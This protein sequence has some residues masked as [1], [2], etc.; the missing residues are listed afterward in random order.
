MRGATGITH[1]HAWGPKSKRNLPKTVEGQFTIRLDHDPNMKLQNWTRSLAEVTFSPL[2]N[3]FCIENYRIFAL[4]LAIPNFTKCCASTKKATLQ[5]HEMLRLPRK[6]TLMIDPETSFRVRGATSLPLQLNQ[7]FR[8][9]RK[10]ALQKSKRNLRKTDETSCIMSFTLPWSEHD[11]TMIRP[12]SDHEL[13]LLHR[14]P[15]AEVTCRASGDMFWKLHICPNFTKCCTYHEKSHSNI[16]KCCA[17]HGKWHSNNITNCCAY[18]G[19]RR[20]NSS[21]YCTCHPK[22]LSCLILL[23][24]ETSCT[25][26]GATSLTLQLN[27]IL[28]LPRKIAF[29]NLREICGKTD[30]TSFNVIYIAG[31]I[32]T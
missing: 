11:P 5:D 26:C 30:E 25:M 23:T 20:S 21:K 19:K 18:Y 22:W 16:T 28:R 9:P 2:R 29:Q 1:C 10:I 8:L 17:Y 31:P 32:R 3:A 15:L 14:R 6:M 7:I 4:R 13:V 27:Q 12:W 24:N